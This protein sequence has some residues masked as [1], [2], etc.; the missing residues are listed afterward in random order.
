M[1]KENKTDE[2]EQLISDNHQDESADKSEKTIVLATEILPENLIIVPLRSRPLFP[3]MVM[4]ILVTGRFIKSV[5]I[6]DGDNKTLGIILSKEKTKEKLFEKD[7]Y[8]WG[9]AAKI[10]GIHKNP[11]GTLQVLVRTLKRFKIDKFLRFSPNIVARVEYPK[12]KSAEI[13]MESKALHRSII[14]ETQT[15]IKENQLISE[16]MKGVLQSLDS[17]KPGVLADLSASLTSS[18]PA[19]LQEV[20]ETINV[21]KRMRKVLLLLKKEVDLIHLQQEISNEIQEKISKQQREYFLREQL[22]VIKR[23]LG[24]EMDDK[25]LELQ[26]IETKL[27]QLKL[28]KKIREKIDKEV[29]KMKLTEAH[30]PEFGVI[31]NYL[32]IFTS[33]PWI[34]YSRDI[35]DLNR[36]YRI[37]N[38]D[39]YGL[40]DIKDRIIEFIATMKIKKSVQGSII[41]LVGPPGVGKTSVGRSIARALNRKFYRFSLGGMRDEAEIKGHRRTYI[42]AM[43]GKII[44]GIKYCGTSNPVIML[45]EIDK[46]SHSYM[47]DPSSALLEVL[48]PEQNAEFVDHY[49]DIPYDLSRV[50]FITTAN[51]LDTIPSPLRDRME[52]MRLSGYIC[53]EK[54]E[55]GRRFLLTKQLKAHGLSK[56][57]LDINKNALARIANDY[58][59]EAGVRNM[60]KKIARICRKVVTQIAKG[61]KSK[62]SINVRNL[63]KFLGKPPFLENPLEQENPPGV[64]TGLAWTSLGG[65]VLR[66]ES[67]SISEKRGFKQTGQLGDVMVESSNIAYSYINSAIE[68]FGG[69]PDYFDKHFLHLH[70]PEGATPKDGPSAGIT[71]ALSI[72]SLALEKKVKKGLAMTGELTLTGNVLPIGGLREKI[73]AARR[74]KL[75]EIII[76]KLNQTAYEELKD[77]LKKDL[78]FHLVNHFSEIPEIAFQD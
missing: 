58:A 61:D 41:C 63:K 32:D 66:V 48:D 22:K 7:L 38:Q 50:L 3:G 70:V 19:E 72:L 26:R 67:V 14:I 23:E 25:S 36:A 11:D 54:V 17:S 2:K 29:Q 69:T 33:L 71:M 46:L 53:R 21:K 28:P 64:T 60:E 55:I 24:L 34:S 4:P 74:N 65:A 1:P 20:L 47:G 51:T 12:K 30:S 49:L 44:N 9:T 43:P 15:I 62:V 37:L 77:Y 35:T 39:H 6:S 31:R 13:S 75:H 40:Q 8:S 18:E 42:G 76:P 45:D 73:I 5:H 68:Q 57:N 78:V 59:R 56:T 52:V 27:K 16:E 10:M